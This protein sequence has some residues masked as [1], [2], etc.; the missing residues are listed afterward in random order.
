MTTLAAMKSVTP[1]QLNEWKRLGTSFQLIDI[2]EEHEVAEESMQGLHIPMDEVIARVS[3][4][5]TDKPVVIHC[6]SGRRST[7]LVH[8]LER[9]FALQNLY[10]LEGGISA[11]LEDFS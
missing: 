3:E 6:K 11:Y 8:M 9:K 10:T 1:Q 2:R 5:E 7:A 4:L